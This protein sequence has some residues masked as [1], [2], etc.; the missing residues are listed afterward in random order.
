MRQTLLA[1]LPA[2]SVTLSDGQIDT[3][4]RFGEALIEKNAVMNLTAITEPSAV[5][6]LHFLDCIALLNAADFHGKRVIDVGCGAGFPGVPLKIAEPSI[7]LTLLDSLAKR[8]NWL[9]E[10]LPALGVDAEII[11][12]RAEE[13]AAQ[14]R[15]QY[16]LATSRAVARLNVLA[17]LCLPYV[18]VGGKFLAM[19]GALAQEEVEEARRGIERLGGHVLRIFEYPVADAVHKAVV[20]E[21]LRPTPPQYPRAFAKIKKSP[22]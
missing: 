8:M 20:I 19:K 11:T 3:L 1:G 12:A 21:K 13:F 10:T 16:D 5:A 9:S 17:E 4:C 14:R 22:L 7:R 18:R 6:Q 2:Y 15:E